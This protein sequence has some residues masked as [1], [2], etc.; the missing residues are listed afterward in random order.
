MSVREIEDLG[1]TRQREVV[2]KVIR[3][4]AEHLTANE[5]FAKATAISSRLLALRTSIRNPRALAAICT[6]LV[7]AWAVMEFLGLTSRAIEVAVGTSWCNS[8]TRFAEPTS[9]N[10][11]VT[12]TSHR[13][14]WASTLQ[15]FDSEH[16]RPAPWTPAAPVAG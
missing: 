1:L 12:L 4:A 11:R 13:P 16:F 15:H 2:L 5:V 10:D 3:E 7:S 14:G 6:S 8:W 9:P